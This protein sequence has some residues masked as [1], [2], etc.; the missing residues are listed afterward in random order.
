MQVA[1]D[2]KAVKR[3]P[4]GLKKLYVLGGLLV[5]QYHDAMKLTSHSKGKQGKQVK[6]FRSL[7][8]E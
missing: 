5:E 8:G 4:L 7:V 3:S 2:Q 6:H 1:E